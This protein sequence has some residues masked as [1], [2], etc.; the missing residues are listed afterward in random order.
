MTA[1]KRSEPERRSLSPDFTI[2]EIDKKRTL[3]R[4]SNP[5]AKFTKSAEGIAE[6]KK[7]NVPYPDTPW[8]KA[9]QSFLDRTPDVPGNEHRDKNHT[10]IT[11][12]TRVRLPSGQEFLT[13]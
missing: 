12:I 4:S 13:W 11:A 9:Y 5:N 7:F 10:H 8:D 6:F 1:T 3:G 2:E